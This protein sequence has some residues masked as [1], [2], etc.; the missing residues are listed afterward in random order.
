L[1]VHGLGPSPASANRHAR[2]V[3]R[4]RL[5]IIVGSLLGGPQ[6]GLASD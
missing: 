4:M 6:R 1:A 3:G 5:E 2:T